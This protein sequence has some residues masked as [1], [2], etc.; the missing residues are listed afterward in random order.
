[1]SYSNVLYKNLWLADGTGEALRKGAVLTGAGIVLAIEPEISA[2]AAEQTIDLGG[3]IL[4]PG[5]IDAHGHSDLSI[6]ASPDGFGKVSQGVVAE[7]VGNC[8]L[9][10]FPVTEHNRS[11]LNE[12]YR[13]YGIEIDWNDYA[14]W[15]A[16][17]TKRGVKLKMRA[18]CGHNTLRAAVVGYEQSELSGQELDK[19]SH[20]LRE[21]MDQGALGLS[22][23]LI[24]VPG[25]FAD[26]DEVVYL[27]KILAERNALYATHLRSEGDYLLESLADTIECAHRAGLRRL[28]ISHFKTAGQVNWY[29]LEEAIAQ[30]EE[31]RKAGMELF[32]DRYPYTESMTQL[33]VILPKGWDHLDDETL[34]HRLRDP[35]M[36][37]SL[38][39]A[40]NQSRS[41]EY[42]NTVRLVSTSA[43]RF[44]VQEGK[45][46]DQIAQQFQ[47]S[48]P[49]LVVEL[50][51][52]DATGTTAGFQGMS[53]DNLRKI[54]ALPYC[55]VG[56]DENARPLDY[57]MGRS[58]PRAFGS[59]PRFL[60]KRL[61]NGASIE[62]A[63][64][65]AT[66]L[67]ADAF[68]LSDLGYIAPGR[69]A[70][71][72]A[73]NPEELDGCNDFA[74]PHTPASGLLFTVID[75]KMVYHS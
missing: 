22:T 40:L 71:F 43:P 46:L 36:R 48:V 31:V 70:D 61:E 19:M 15:Q 64:R 9:S 75:G 57:S 73:F 60:K 68:H 69:P 56:S 24:Y 5:F 52:T 66:G 63:V 51:A 18:L 37:Q 34:E 62:S 55:M 21:M 41:P 2:S 42:W 58:H 27:M 32:I 72:V 35:R 44:N 20:L 28:Q 45:K 26:A 13:Q 54:L 47:L 33:S 25:K 10:A 49:A 67:A 16:S 7:I 74:N 59:L 4:A 39:E 1:M 65:Q 53:E 12:L 23:G 14:G 3:Q 6:L 29:K 17:I 11:H 50:L 8:G 30:L 38:E